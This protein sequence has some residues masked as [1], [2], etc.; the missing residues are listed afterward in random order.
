MNEIGPQT[1]RNPGLF[2]AKGLPSPASGTGWRRETLLPMFGTISD[3]FRR[4]GTSSRADRTSRRTAANIR[5]SIGPSSSTGKSRPSR[6]LTACSRER[7]ERS[8]RSPEVILQLLEFFKT[9]CGRFLKTAEVFRRTKFTTR[10]KTPVRELTQ[11]LPYVRLGQAAV[12]RAE[13]DAFLNALRITAIDPAL[14]LRGA[15]SRSA[16]FLKFFADALARFKLPFLFRP[17]QAFFFRKGET[18]ILVGR[19][20]AEIPALRSPATSGAAFFCGEDKLFG[21]L[22]FFRR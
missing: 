13:S 19:I 12:H 21:S 17:N 6:K 8:L 22:N 15:S 18:F 10:L 1:G 14:L 7:G 20:A 9:P 16:G 11:H 2:P 3:T 4:R 5:A